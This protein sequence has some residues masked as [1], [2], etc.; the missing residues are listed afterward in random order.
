MWTSS[1][2]S[3]C[4]TFSSRLNYEKQQE[5]ILPLEDN[6]FYCCQVKDSDS[7]EQPL[8]KEQQVLSSRKVQYG[9][10]SE[11]EHNSPQITSK[12]VAFLICPA[13]FP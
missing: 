9:A 10:P 5:D 12:H 8:T 7:T 1:S 3:K 6:H 13:G 11:A 4:F 2:F